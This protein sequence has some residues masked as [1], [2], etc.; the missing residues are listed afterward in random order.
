[1]ALQMN[2]SGNRTYE[3]A[4][5]GAYGARLVRVVDEGWRD[6]PFPRDEWVAKHELRLT[7]LITAP[8]SDG[9]PFAISEWVR[10]ARR[11]A[12]GNERKGALYK[13]DG[14][15]ST[16]VSRVEALS[17]R[18]IEELHIERYESEKELI[19]SLIGNGCL[20]TT[21]R[22]KNNKTRISAVVMAPAGIPLPDAG[23]YLEKQSQ[24][25]PI[26]GMDERKRI[27][28]IWATASDRAAHFDMEKRAG[29]EMIVRSV[30]EAHEIQGG[31][32]EVVNLPVPDIRAIVTAISWW[33]PPVS[34]PAQE[35]VP[36]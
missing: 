1:M 22:N 16:F 31:T 21:K 15:M 33:E 10:L 4:P 8:M 3:E 35:E 14:K 34:Q 2:Q 29:A 27:A 36:F 25:D 24:E 19:E 7:Y 23:A 11:D 6:D 20:V 32:H 13:K 28:L 26:A 17:G 12:H 30:Y 9:R 18:E 5:I